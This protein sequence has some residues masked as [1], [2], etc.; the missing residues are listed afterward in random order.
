MRQLSFMYYAQVENPDLVALHKSLQS[1]VLIWILIDF[2]A[3]VKMKT[4]N[5]GVCI[6][7]QKYI[8]VNN[9]KHEIC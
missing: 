5:V 6:C 8:K 1:R 9:Q 7:F 3:N 4:K 2:F